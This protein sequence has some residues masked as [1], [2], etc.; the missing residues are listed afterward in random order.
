MPRRG[1]IVLARFP[2]TD[3]NGAKL[4]PVLILLETPGAHQDFMVMFVS[5]R[6]SQ[7]VP[8]LDV[9][10][11]QSRPS[12]GGSGLRTAS[13][14][15]VGKVASMSHALIAGTLGHLDSVVF[16]DLVHRLTR[17]LA[18]GRPPTAFDGG[19]GPR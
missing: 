18:T 1:D 10:L 19:A 5:S 15:R 9:I 13:V 2:F 11:D 6:R 7:A 4:R 3:Q 14:F 12:F 8:G 16:D 17:L